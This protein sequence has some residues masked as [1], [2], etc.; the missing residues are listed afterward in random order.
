MANPRPQ[1]RQRPTGTSPGHRSCTLGLP[2]GRARRNSAEP[3]PPDHITLLDGDRHIA[4]AKGDRVFL[5]RYEDL[6]DD[7]GE[8]LPITERRM[9][10]PVRHLQA[11]PR[12]GSTVVV[13]ALEDD[14]LWE[15]ELPGAASYQS[16]P[17]N[18]RA[19]PLTENLGG[20]ASHLIA[21][22]RHILVVVEEHG[23]SGPMLVELDPITA[24]VTRRAP[25]PLDRL[26]SIAPLDPERSD[27]LVAVDA[28]HGAHLVGFPVDDDGSI[29][30]T[31]PFEP[32]ARVTAAAAIDDRWVAVARKGGEVLLVRRAPGVGGRAEDAAETCRRLRESLRHEHQSETADDGDPGRPT[33]GRPDPGIPDDEPC[34]ERRRANL[35]WTIAALHKVGNHLIAVSAR[36]DRMAV[37]DHKLDVMFELY[38]GN[39]GAVLASGAATTDRMIVLRRGSSR[40][41]AWS[42]DAYIRGLRGP[43]LEFPEWRRPPD[44][45]HARTVTFHGR[46][47][48]PG[49]PNPDLKVAVFTVTEP[50]QAFG[51]P[52]QS[53]MQA[54]LEPNV[55]SVVTDYYEEISFS[56]VTPEF[57]VFGVHLGTPRRPLVLPRAIASYFYDDFFPGGIEAVMPGNWASPLVLDGSEAMTLHSEPSVGVGR[58][59]PVRFAALWTSR[60]H[61]AYPVAVSFTGTETLQVNVVDQTGTAR[62]LTLDFGALNL[63]HAQGDDE[64]AFL[65]A[66][67]QHV[68]N[69]VRTAEAAAGAPRVIEDVVFR[70]IRS[71]DDD[72]VFGRLQGQFRV[73]AAAGASQKGQVSITVPGAPPAGLVALGL[74]DPIPR[75]GVLGSR[76]QIVDYLA[77]CLHATRY[78]AGEGAGLNDP[79]LATAVVATEDATTQQVRVRIQLTNEKGGPGAHITLVSSSGLTASGWST[80]TPVL[81]SQSTSN[82]QNTL[83]DHQNLANDV[84][85]AAM[86]HIRASGPWNPNAVRA[87]FADFDVMVIGF[88]GACPTTTTAGLTVPPADRWNSA[89]PVD[90]SRLRMFKRQHQ[91][92]DLNNPIPFFPAVTMGTDVVIG[93]RFNQFD[94]GVMSHEIG[95]GLGLPDLYRE[96]G[97]RD[98]V[99]YLDRW[100]QMAGGNSRFNHFCA[101]SKWSVGWIVK[102]PN[103]SLNRVIDVPMPA[104][105]GTTTTEAWLVPVEHWDNT[106]RADVVAEVGSGLPIG[107]MMKV[108]LGSDGGVVDLIEFRSPGVK[109]SQ[110]LLPTPA[111][112]VTNVLDPWTDRR[113]AVKR[114]GDFFYRRHAHLLNNGNELLASGDSWD[115]AA[116][117]E[118][119]L[120]GCRV[121]IA[122]L[123]SI[124]GGTIPICRL[125]VQ[126]EAAEF[127]DLYFQDNVP[128]WHSPDI[129]VDWPGDNPDP[130]IPRTYPE[131]TPTDQGEAVRFPGSGVEPHFLVVRPHNAG[132][133][134]AEDVKLR[135]FICDPPGGGDDNRWEERDTQTLPQV[136]G[137]VFEIGPFT[138]NVD[139]GTNSHVCL[140]AE[141]IDWT[142]PSGVDPATGDT[143]ALSS[144]DVVLQNNLAQKNVID[145]EALT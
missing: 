70:R 84:F 77:E 48:S 6:P 15:I 74:T 125:R 40:I 143:V 109:F 73:A 106:M 124:R 128:S 38:L 95:H 90:F 79:H 93:Q 8:V 103:P 67:G 121:Q 78:D 36:G 59:Y 123:R 107:Q 58:D 25:L 86:D 13:V 144:D 53:R 71:N 115:F 52:N 129:W 114:D 112:I 133:V 81:G 44:P 117:K 89:N 91:A 126:R 142:I 28:R 118:F 51:D 137:G 127:I 131:G 111:V 45:R 42:L 31:T 87:Q 37:L 17:E 88:V 57:S 46:R 5:Y 23:R 10:A 63:S 18:P 130:T 66:L 132:N 98:D 33:G 26:T 145:F 116:G 135:W 92:K 2:T 7:G 16:R 101:Y 27:W 19:R 140:R 139:P 32:S 64:A 9:A 55:Y 43:A 11:W 99:L 21:T 62:A 136:D 24:T 108:H 102:S 113:W 110:Q 35:G 14:S 34:E 56:T 4:A 83:R 134:R 61:N 22:R 60:T 68:T 85:T 3:T 80:A 41:E 119:P 72:A 120:K 12:D 65:A 39:R 50:G 29:V 97:F 141:I 82:N 138:W 20:R 30:Q 96:T 54:L 69:A 100:C 122:E 94:P 75:D 76:I 47:S 49:T 104:P 105:S 1:T